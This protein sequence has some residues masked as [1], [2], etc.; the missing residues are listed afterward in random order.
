M[1][2]LEYIKNFG[3]ITIKKVCNKA[4]VDYSNLMNGRIKDINKI[5]LVKKIIEQEVAKLYI[6]QDED[7]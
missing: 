6:L 2:E 1:Q 3:K 7:K 5:R 4:K